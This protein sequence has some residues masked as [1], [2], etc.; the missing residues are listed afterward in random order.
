MDSENKNEGDKINIRELLRNTKINAKANRVKQKKEQGNDTLKVSELLRQ[1]RVAKNVTQVEMANRLGMS[2]NGYG[3]I[4]RGQTYLT[5]TKIKEIA[6]ALDISYSELLSSVEGFE[7]EKTELEEVKEN[8]QM[9]QLQ[10]ENKDLRLRLA[11]QAKEVSKKVTKRY[12]EEKRLLNQ[13]IAEK[14]KIISLLEKRI[15]ILEHELSGGFESLQ[16]AID[17]LG[18]L[19]TSSELPK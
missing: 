2:Q 1:V 15:A 11:T 12:V 10:Q 8:E 18:K 6:K 17:R 5:L 4:E 3:K 13:N 14:D 19:M 9:V 7:Q 16:K